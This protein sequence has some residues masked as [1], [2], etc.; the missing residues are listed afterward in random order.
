MILLDDLVRATGGDVLSVGA[1][2]SCA[3]FAHDSRRLAPGDCFVA[4]RGAHADGHD[5]LRD[6]AAGGAGAVLID[7]RHRQSLAADEWQAL[8]DAMREAG[9]TVV[10]VPDTRQAVTRYARAI[11]AEWQ[12]LVVAVTGS[13]GK[14]T[15]KEAIADVLALQ[16]PTFRSWRNYNDL[17][18]LPLTLGSL[19][20]HH[21]YAVVEMGCDHPGEIQE[22]CEIAQPTIGVV[23]NVS[24]THLQYFGSVGG[25]AAE[26]NQLPRALPSDGYAVLNAGDPAVF[27]MGADTGAGLLLFGPV[28][29]DTPARETDPRQPLRY[30]VERGS[31]D[32]TPTLTLRALDDPQTVT[33]FAHLHGDH[34]ATAVLAAA[35]VGVALGVPVTEALAT[36]AD[37]RPLPGRLNPFTGQD[38]IT[39]LDDS[40]NAAPASVA[41]GLA[42]LGSWPAPDMPRIAMLGDMLRLGGEE[43]RA[44]RTAGRHAARVAS[45]LVTLGMRAELIADEARR[46]GLPPERIAV[47]RTAEDAARAVLG[48]ARSAHQSVA[49]VKASEEMRAE[50][51]TALLLAQPERAPELL[52]RQSPER[53]RTITMRPD[54]PTWLEVDLGAIGG[55]SRLI[56]ARVGERVQV[57]V[58]LKA[59]AYGHGAL[60]VA[61]T[62]LRNG[63]DWLGVATVS[64]AAPVRAAGVS[65]SILIFGYTA[66]WQAREAIRLD[67]RAT[68]YEL[69]SARALAQ[70]AADLRSVA[71]V[72]VKVDTG[73]GRLGLRAEW[74]S[75][76]VD[77]VRMLRDLPHLEVE[78]LFTQIAT[79]D[80]A[81]PT[82]ALRQIE[83]F[84]AVLRALTEAGLR[85]PL[86]HAANS[87]AIFAF[88]Q[89]HYDMVRPGIAIYGLPPSADVP[90]PPGFRPALEFKTQ[91]AQVKD[92]P[93]GEG[94]SYGAT[95]VTTAPTRVATLPVGYADGFRRGP[96]NWGDVLIRGQR[97]PL[98]GRVTMDQCM[99]DIT[100]IPQARI[101]DEVVLIGR[102]GD[103]ELTA[104]AV[105]ERLGTIHYE[106]VAALL[107]RVPR[108]S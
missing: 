85:P 60:A 104:T 56:K 13:T 15:T 66:P 1:R 37:L 80:S 93:A 67:L 103:D 11:L 9:V 27:A 6:A 71:R 29:A 78:G 35:T 49:L 101:G 64:E 48:F 106:V 55:N 30:R 91:V 98:L 19:E 18:G 84:E 43:E 61:R 17:L 76:V 44:H 20:P 73:M 81:D 25:L 108:V 36:L 42:V 51:V 75:E 96:R 83:R 28:A 24:A 4:V 68:V 72:H 39:L 89:A 100:Q 53:Q 52:D 26:L 77:F 47:T 92:V 45:H 54:R 23:T 22:L 88:S 40:H 21:R 86:V 14:T 102:Q 31:A 69:E 5:F 57:L 105:A 94:I 87:A 32:L 8:Y 10:E 12:P 16:A 58:S 95:Y 2:A 38:G 90:L 33:R 7:A 41:A 50:R 46:S 99:A 107:A 74:V 3:A 62:V 79:A 97:A 70:A 82:Y 34:W 59:D 65:A 63:A